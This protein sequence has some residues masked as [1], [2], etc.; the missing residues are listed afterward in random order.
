M[1]WMARLYETYPALAK[2]DELEKPWPVS[3]FVKNAHVEVV[4]DVLG[5]IKKNRCK[6]INGMDAPTLIPATESSSGRSGDTNAPH[7]LC[8]ELGYCAGDL[9]SVDPEKFEKYLS[10]LSSWAKH[11]PSQSKLKAVLAYIEKRSLYKDLSETVGLP[12]KIEKRDG[13]KEKIK[14]EKVFVR[15]VIEIPGN[16]QSSTWKDENL[17]SSWIDYDKTLHTDSGFCFITSNTAR[18]AKNHPRY[19]RRPGDG[20]R[21]VSSNDDDGF[22]FRG[23]FTDSKTT[24]KNKGLQGCGISYEVSQ[25]AHSALRRLIA[26]QGHKFGESKDSPGAVIVAWAVSGNAIPDPMEDSFALLSEEIIEHEMPALQGISTLVDHCLNVGQQFAT[27]LN[28]RLA[29]YQAKLP[30]SDNIII[31]GLDS[32]TPGRMGITYYQEFYRDDFLNR[33]TKWHEDF[34]WPQR[35]KI[36]IDE[37]KRKPATKTI[38]PIGAP[39]PKAIWQAAYGDTISDALK[40][41]TVERIL[42]C[43]VEAR[44]FPFDI[45]NAAIH[46]AGNRLLKRLP[47]KYSNDESEKA[48]WEENLCVACSLYKGFHIRHPNQRKEYNMA[49]DENYHSRDYLYGRLLAIAE[50]IEE[51]ALSIAKEKERSTTAARFMQRFSDHPASTWLTIEKALVPYQQRLRSN[52]AP[53][54]AAYK[55]LLDD[56]CD[57]FNTADFNSKERLTGEYLLG[58]HCQRKWLLDH[59]L[60]DGQWIL[61]VDLERNTETETKEGDK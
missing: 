31:M 59:K 10:Q 32:A 14:D 5:N 46:R 23:R 53:L 56:V 44:P 16:P 38:W 29:G 54:E 2:T 57:D 61:K 17:I 26:R 55:R 37:G 11:D 19:I 1:S 49:L 43:I 30:P 24:I 39:S 58:F 9:P 41:S 27:S 50:R 34:A 35:H 8:E 33:I 42:P 21:L 36:E 3:H 4:L 13:S 45:V 48:A 15:W 6:I 25:K 60:K 20:A 51:V 28:K 22:T 18:L 40:K 52:I 12:V 47:K 7:P